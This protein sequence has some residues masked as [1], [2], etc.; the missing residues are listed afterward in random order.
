MQPNDFL[1]AEITAGDIE[2][3]A[4]LLPGSFRILGANLF[5][6]VFLADADGAVHQLDIGAGGISVIA[7]S[8]IEFREGCTEDEE[9]W[10][11]R[12]LIEHC[13]QEG[14]IPGPGE[15]YAY[16]TMPMFK[17]GSYDPDNIVVRPVKEWLGFAGTLYR[18]TRNLPAGAT[19]ELQ[20]TE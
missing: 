14:K 12:P 7:A 5:A 1:Q 19:V 13:R 4:D 10:L 3:W 16:L 20:V 8:E 11:L 6:D 18:E 2:P 15:C 9:L 17:E